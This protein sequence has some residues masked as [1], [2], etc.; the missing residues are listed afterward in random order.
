MKLLQSYLFLIFGCFL[1]M[2]MLNAAQDQM[3]CSDKVETVLYPFIVD[4]IDF[5]LLFYKRKIS[6]INV[7][8][9]SVAS[10]HSYYVIYFCDGKFP[11]S[12]RMSNTDAKIAFTRYQLDLALFVQ[13]KADACR[14]YLALVY[15]ADVHKSKKLFQDAFTYIC[16]CYCSEKKTFIGGYGTL[17]Q[18]QEMASNFWKKLPSCFKDIQ[19]Y[20]NYVEQLFQKCGLRR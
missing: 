11:T 14:A 6:E 3:S 16:G 2:S 12:I 1:F 20:Q 5:A 10:P 18:K 4:D 8:K 9:R 19:I 15:G 17:E 13:N 7:C